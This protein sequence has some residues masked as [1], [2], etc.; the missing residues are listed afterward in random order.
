MAIADNDYF[1][2]QT[3]SDC[4]T[5]SITIN[6]AADFV[7]YASCPDLQTL[8]VGPAAGPE[9]D[10][11]GPKRIL[12][13][14]ILRNNSLLNTLKSSSL[15]SIAGKFNLNDVTALSTLQFDVLT[16]VKSIDWAGLPFLISLTLPQ[17]ISTADSVVITNTNIESL[18]GINLKKVGLLD[19]NNNGRLKKFDTQVANISQGVNIAGNS[20][21]LIV[22]FPNLLWAN[23]MTFRDVQGLTTPSLATVNGSLIFVNNGFSEYVAPN[24]TSVG[25]VG[26]SQGSFAF[27]GNNKL[28]NISFPAITSIGGAFQVANN[29]ALQEIT[30]KALERVGGAIDL[31]GN[32][33]T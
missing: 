5:K 1:S 6:S 26:T 11:T 25:N 2:A 29:S 8:I 18:D 32:F 27:V 33:T 3:N 24:L 21:S 17:T 28:N 13:D 4:T 7:K 30:M 15:A 20:K 16:S 10:I 12:G 23:N 19:I 22:S 9:I 31:S 14:L